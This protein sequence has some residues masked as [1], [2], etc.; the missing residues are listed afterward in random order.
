MTMD[1]LIQKIPLLFE[2][3]NEQ[4]TE[5]PLQ[6]EVS[7]AGYLESFSAHL[8]YEIEEPENASVQD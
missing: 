3:P 6:Y 1:S 7:E 4:F 5:R 2:Q 8:I